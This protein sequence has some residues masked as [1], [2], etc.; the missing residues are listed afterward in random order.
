MIEPKYKAGES[1]IEPRDCGT[2]MYVLRLYVAGMTP[3]SMEAID[4][5]RKICEEH[6]KGRFEIECIDIYLHPELALERQV[7]VAPMLIKE[8][9]LPL[10]TYIGQMSDEKRILKELDIMVKE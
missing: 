8:L 7:L 4:S 3:R 1:G 6:L 5:I 10:R 9:P 2:Q